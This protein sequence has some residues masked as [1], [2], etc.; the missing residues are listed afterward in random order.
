VING[1]SKTS[2]SEF[3]VG[4]NIDYINHRD[5]GADKNLRDKLK[6]NGDY[7]TFFKAIARSVLNHRER[8]EE[9]NRM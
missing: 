4:K 2:L 7:K 9:I 1:F 8:L 5:L 6:K 3:L